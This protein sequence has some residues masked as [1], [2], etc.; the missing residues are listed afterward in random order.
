MSSPIHQQN[1]N[2]TQ[3]KVR[4]TKT[5]MASSKSTSN[6]DTRQELAELIRRK[7]EITVLN[8]FKT[9]D[10]FILF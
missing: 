2:D 3:L 7:A 5:N 10:L 6:L 8:C 1:G 4:K 9:F